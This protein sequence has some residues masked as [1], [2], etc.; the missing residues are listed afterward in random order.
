MTEY[1]RAHVP[2]ACYFFTVNL[3]KRRGNNLLIRE[4]ADLREAFRRVRRVAG[5]PADRQ[6]SSRYGVFTTSPRAA[7]GAACEAENLSRNHRRSIAFS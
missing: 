5:H 6:C 4:I 1:R 2:G 7:S 3:G